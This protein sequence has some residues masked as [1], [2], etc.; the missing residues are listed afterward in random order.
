MTEDSSSQTINDL[1]IEDSTN[2]S[3]GAP[4]GYRVYAG[5][6]GGILAISDSTISDNAAE[7]IVYEGDESLTISDSTI[8]NNGGPDCVNSSCGLPTAGLYLAWNHR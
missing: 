2:A 5:L 3:S 6:S 7:G 8:A 4:D 1:T